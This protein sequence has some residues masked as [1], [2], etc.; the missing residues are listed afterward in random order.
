MFVWGT[1]MTFLN[2]KTF[3]N[4]NLKVT[5]S[6]RYSLVADKLGRSRWAAGRKLPEGMSAC[7]EQAEEL[8]ML[9]AKWNS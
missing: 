6:F 8:Q 1:V 7:K 4:K 2:Q 9:I 3:Q 5:E